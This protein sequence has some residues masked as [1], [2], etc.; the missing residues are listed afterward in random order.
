[1]SKISNFLNQLNENKELQLKASNNCPEDILY[2][3]KV[4]IGDTLKDKNGNI[5]NN[6]KGL[7]DKLAVLSPD[8]KT[9]KVYMADFASDFTVLEFTKDEMRVIA[10]MF[11]S[12]S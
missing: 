4:A 3:S 2:Q 9:I 10:N 12:H 1:M 6:V 5:L 7:D 11:R 8:G